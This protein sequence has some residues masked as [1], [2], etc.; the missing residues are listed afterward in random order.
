MWVGGKRLPDPDSCLK[1]ADALHV[2]P[3]LVLTL[4][5][6]RPNVEALKPDDPRVDLIALARR[7]RW[8][9]EREAVA[10]AVL[11]AYVEADRKGKG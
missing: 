7:V 9:G 6:H 5:G 10:R 11:T 1:I 3:D 4:A 2:D 8:T